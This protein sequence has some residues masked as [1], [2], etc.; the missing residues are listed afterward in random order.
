MHW[1][2]LGY[3]KR[4]SNKMNF[5][6]KGNDVIMSKVLCQIKCEV[7]S[8]ITRG[9]GTNIFMKIGS[10]SKTPKIIWI[11]HMKHPLRV[12]PPT[13]LTSKELSGTAAESIIHVL[14]AARNFQRSSNYV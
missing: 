14:K 7:S 6:W 10:T 4:H 11:E 2:E 5:Q 12:H 9:F 1:L 13:K 8:A 3:I